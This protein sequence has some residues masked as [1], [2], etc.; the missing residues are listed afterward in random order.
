MRLKSSNPAFGSTFET[1]AVFV[2]YGETMT[3]G[4]TAN[5]A[6]FLMLLVLLTAAF[7]W[8]SFFD[9]PET[10]NV[11]GYMMLGLIG[12]FIAAMVTIFKKEW[13]AVTAPVYAL[14]EGLA[15]G[16]IS[17]TLEYRFP[18][19][20]IEAVALTFG[21]CFCL[22]LAYR[23][24]L[25]RASEKFTLGIVAATGGIALVYFANMILS[26]FGV[27]M[28]G[29]FGSGPVG[30]L[31]SLVVV[32]VAALNLI[33]DFAFIEEGAQRGAPKYM[34]WYGAFGLMVTLIWLYLEM[35]RL[36]SKLRDDRN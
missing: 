6:G 22:L 32:V 14:F 21:T 19:I 15:L 33:L 27:H 16:G 10:A 36:L 18:G 2:G 29:I 9:N 11:G 26:I 28:P 31:F 4:G 17:A 5:K 35:I 13:S 20:A 25:I 12:G 7:T 1:S 3:V 23:S 8:N 34:E 24:G 30:I